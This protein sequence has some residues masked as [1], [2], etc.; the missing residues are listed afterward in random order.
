MKLM[1]GANWWMPNWLGIVLRISS[2]KPPE[3]APALPA[4]VPAP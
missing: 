1:G 2:P 4:P 3:L